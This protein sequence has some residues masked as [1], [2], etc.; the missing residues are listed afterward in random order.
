M[1]VHSRVGT[2]R[3]IFIDPVLRL[4]LSPV[5]AKFHCG[6]VKVS[7]ATIGA[8]GRALF[9]ISSLFFN[10]IFIFLCDVFLELR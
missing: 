5:I 1:Q 9:Y 8:T 7:K 2:F 10:I 4:N 6:I 3:A